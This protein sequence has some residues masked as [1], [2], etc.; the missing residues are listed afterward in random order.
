MVN[1]GSQGS[2]ADN[3][4][5]GKSTATKQL[6][7]QEEDKLFNDEMFRVSEKM[8]NVLTEQ[9]AKIF[10]LFDIRRLN[11]VQFFDEGGNLELSVPA[12]MTDSAAQ[13][14][15]NQVGALDR[16]LQNK[17]SEYNNL[18]RQDARLYDSN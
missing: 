9:E 6:S 11:N 16:A 10:K 5:K 3:S 14:L 2:S 18:S 8:Y 17:F 1:S 13:N 7:S 12:G 15:S 4:S